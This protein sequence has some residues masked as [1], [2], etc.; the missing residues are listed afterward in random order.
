MQLNDLERKSKLKNLDEFENIEEIKEYLETL[1]LSELL[2][3]HYIQSCEINRIRNIILNSINDD[4]NS[5]T[6]KD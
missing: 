2:E 1:N 3:I 5:T 4:N 6:S